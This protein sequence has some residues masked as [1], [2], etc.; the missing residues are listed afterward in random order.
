MMGY[1]A[2]AG[3]PRHHA[4]AWGLAGKAVVGAATSG[5]VKNLV[6]SLADKVI[7]NEAVDVQVLDIGF[8]AYWLSATGYTN[9]AGGWARNWAKGWGRPCAAGVRAACL[10]AGMG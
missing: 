6:T 3:V 5:P 8:W 4:H 7:I 2:G 10:W 1:G 9:M